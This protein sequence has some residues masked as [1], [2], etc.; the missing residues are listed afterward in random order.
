MKLPATDGATLAPRHEVTDAMVERALCARVP[1]GSQV[2]VWLPQADAW[3]PH[4]TARDVMRCALDAA[5]SL[6]GDKP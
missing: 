4:Q 2:W 1:G 3:T 5:L 6:A